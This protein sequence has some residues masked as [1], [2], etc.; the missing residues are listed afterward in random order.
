MPD[1][2]KGHQPTSITTP[3]HTLTHPFDPWVDHTLTHPFDPWVDHTL[4]HPFNPWVGTLGRVH[5]ISQSAQPIFSKVISFD[6]QPS[7][8]HT[9]SQEHVQSPNVCRCALTP[10]PALCLN[11]HAIEPL[12]LLCHG[13]LRA[14]KPCC[15]K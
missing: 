4:T 12:L 8:N 6:S 15:S 11:L 14:H 2:R 5:H 13:S 9:P 3:H 1:T 7:I 10:H